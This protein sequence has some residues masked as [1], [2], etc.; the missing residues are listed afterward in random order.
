MA[1]LLI[2]KGLWSSRF[3]Y[4]HNE[5][6]LAE[7]NGVTKESSKYLDPSNIPIDQLSKFTFV[8]P[9]RPI[10]EFR[11]YSWARFGYGVIASDR[12]EN[13]NTVYIDID[14]VYAGQWKKMTYMSS[15]TGYLMSTGKR[16]MVKLRDIYG[17][18]IVQ[19]LIGQV[20]FITKLKYLTILVYLHWLILVLAGTLLTIRKTNSTKLELIKKQGTG[21]MS[22]LMTQVGMDMKREIQQRQGA[23][24]TFSK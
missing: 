5:N 7:M 17:A 16:R 12:D 23:I 4:A 22:F 10:G 13:G 2:K 21:T 15:E 3:L 6:M 11:G 24:F 1:L 20:V 8:A 9:G 18:D 19:T 14:S